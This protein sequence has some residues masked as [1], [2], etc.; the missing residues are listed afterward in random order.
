MKRTQAWTGL[1]IVLAVSLAGC[2][3]TAA[4]QWTYAP[5]PSQAPAAVAVAGGGGAGAP[6]TPTPA[7]VVATTPAPSEV[8]GMGGSAPAATLAPDTTA[9]AY[10]LFDPKAP[11]LMPATEHDID[12]PII[13]TDVTVAPGYVVHAWT[14]GGTVPGPTIRVSIGDTVRVHLT[15]KGQMPH[16]IDFHASQTAMDHQMVAIAPGATF[17]Y[18]FKAEYAGVWMYHCGTAPTLHHIANGMFGMVIVE[19][20][21]GLPRVDREFAFVQSEWYLGGQRAPVDYMK[22]SA[23]APAPD[24]VVFNGV[25]AQ[26]KDNPIEVAAKDRVR[27]FVLDAGPNV[28]SSFHVVGTIFDTVYKEGVA[29]LKGNPDGW[30]SQAV[31]LS[32]AQ[33]AIIELTIPEDGVYAFVTHAFNFVGRG[34]VGV[35]KAGAGATESH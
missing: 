15:N 4:S 33:G 3:G 11:A 19:P 1:A 22:A 12:L 28:D 17:T 29:L 25:A 23:A 32:P 2:G 31:D 18:T 35:F 16:S 26:Y 34:A 27:V 5:A 10:T 13:E 14:F 24:F 7:P 21:G 9:P 30:G 6:A 8:P 20:H